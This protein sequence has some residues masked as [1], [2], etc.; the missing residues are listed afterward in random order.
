[1]AERVAE[2]LNQALHTVLAADDGAYL[3]GEDVLDPYGGAF[4]VTRGLSTRFPEQVLTTPLSENGIVGVAAGL[5]LAGNRVVVEIMFGDFLALALDQVVNFAAKSVSMYG[6]RVPLQLVVR[7]PVGGNRGYGPT[8]SQS[9]QKFLVGVPDLHLWELNPAVDAA[10]VLDRAFAAGCPAVLF[11]DKVLYTKRMWNGGAVDAE[12]S[13]ATD[14]ASLWTFIQHRTEPEPDVILVTAGGTAHRCLD[15]ARALR[16]EHGVSV[17]LALPARLYPCDATRLVERAARAGRVAVVEESTPGGSWGGEVAHAVHDAAWADLLAPVQLVTSRDSVIPTAAHLERDVLVQAGDVV[18]AALRLMQ[19]SAGRRAP[20][21]R[22]AAAPD[23]APPAGTPSSPATAAAAVVEVVVPR[24]NTNDDSA[25]LVEW[26]VTDGA[27]VRQGD[28]VANVE[29]SKASTELPAPATG[30]IRLGRAAGE[31]CAFGASIAVIEFG[32]SAPPAPPDGGTD[33]AVANSSAGASAGALSTARPTGDLGLRP[34]AR[35]RL[36]R[37]QAGVAASVAASH[38]SIPPAFVTVEAR[39]DSALDLLAE[40]AESSGASTDLAALVL[41][42]I[43]ACHADHPAMFASV[44]ADGTPAPRSVPDV[45]V[46]VDAGAGLFLPVIRDVVAL[47]LDDLA[48]RLVALQMAGLGGTFDD[49]DLD[50]TDVGL[51]V[52]L[53]LVPGVAFVEP[54]IMPGLT[55]MLSVGGIRRA[56]VPDEDGQPTAARVITLGLAHDHR[57]VNGRPAAEFLLAVAERLA[58]PERLVAG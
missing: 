30:V 34:P 48:D 19:R 50:L 31:D 46:T 44:A 7:C 38:R 54:L 26:L 53:N 3:L 27:T 6:R 2:N 4:K 18:D 39:V 36:R 28:P 15:A 23:D 11:E 37:V 13:A 29:T 43:G 16:A 52:S 10:T 24:L 40:R 57:V 22:T 51:G 14:P 58:Q 8:H 9:M 32:A 49:R 56:V 47:S 12:W 25:L 35:A 45:A 55:A 17:E 5:A 21:R 42:A 33:Q 20:I 41:A 1:M